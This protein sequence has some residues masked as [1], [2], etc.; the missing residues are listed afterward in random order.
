MQ[1]KF[2]PLFY[3]EFSLYIRNQNLK[4][5]M[6]KKRYKIETDI[7]LQGHEYETFD[8]ICF[9]GRATAFSNKDKEKFVDLVYPKMQDLTDNQ[10][11][12]VRNYRGL[13]TQR[14]SE[15]ADI[16]FGDVMMLFGKESDEKCPVCQ[17]DK[18]RRDLDNPKTMR[19]CEQC[20]SDYTTELEILLNAREIK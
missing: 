1:E 19:C 2:N 17:S 5:K 13:P 6:E 18:T 12:M 20:G 10:K 4:N 11:D 15:D 3:W 14:I 16:H 9:D 8:I 7:E